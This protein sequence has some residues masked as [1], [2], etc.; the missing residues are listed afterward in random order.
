MKRLIILFILLTQLVSAQDRFNTELIHKMND[1]RKTIGVQP[2][3]YN[4]LLD[5]LAQAWSQYISDSL[6]QY[7]MQ[8]LVEMYKTDHGCLHV[9]MNKRILETNAIPNSGIEKFGKFKLYEPIVDENLIISEN[10]VFNPETLISKCFN[11]W[12][13][14]KG[15]FM[16]M[17]EEIYNACGFSYAFNSEKNRYTFLVVFAELK[18]PHK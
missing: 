8:E 16:N 7:T 1:L 11:G 4:P 17:V 3:K 6:D 9:D 10:Y 13:H 14:S 5:S 18:Q 2:L 15:H 12:L